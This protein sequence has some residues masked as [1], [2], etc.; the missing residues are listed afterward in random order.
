MI[1]GKG[2]IA[3]EMRATA[4]TA[5]GAPPPV[6][7]KEWPTHMYGSI[8]ARYPALAMGLSLFLPLVLT[9]VALG[10]TTRI[11][12]ETAAF[13]ATDTKAYK[14]LEA[15]VNARD[16]WEGQVSQDPASPVS[17]GDAS[18]RVRATP[19]YRITLQ[20][21]LQCDDETATAIPARCTTMLHPLN[22]DYVRG[23]EQ[24]ATGISTRFSSVCWINNYY[25]GTTLELSSCAPVSSV[26]Q[27]FYPSVVDQPPYLLLDGRGDSQQTLDENMYQRLL[28]NPQIDWFVDSTFRTSRNTRVLRSQ[29]I[30][31]TPI[32]RG[33]DENDTLDAVDSYVRAMYDAVHAVPKPLGTMQ[34]SVGGDRVVEARVLGRI[35]RESFMAPIAV[36]IIAVILFAHSR[37]IVISCL[38]TI[39]VLFTYL[40]TLSI[41]SLANDGKLPLLSLISLFFTIVWAVDGVLVVYDNFV[42]SGIIATTGRRNTLRV[43]QRIS[44][45]LRRGIK[46]IFIAH[47]CA[48]VAFCLNTVSP[49][50]E[51]KHFAEFMIIMIFVSLYFFATYTP[52]LVLF[53]HFY[54]AKR[55]RNLQRQRDVMLEQGM[56]DRYGPMAALLA[57]MEDIKAVT[58]YTP[59]AAIADERDARALTGKQRRGD[60]LNKVNA[61]AN[62]FSA[63][64][65]IR[66][67]QINERKEV[68]R[69]RRQD[70]IADAAAAAAEGPLAEGGDAPDQPSNEATSPARRSDDGDGELPEQQSNVVR[71]ES[72]AFNTAAAQ[73]A[74]DEFVDIAQGP[75]PREAGADRT[76]DRTIGPL[77]AVRPSMRHI[78][79]SE[80]IH[81]PP[82]LIFRTPASVDYGRRL[83]SARFEAKRLSHNVGVPVSEST[84]LTDTA[85]RHAGNSGN[86]DDNDDGVEMLVLDDH[87]HA[88]TSA[89]ARA[90]APPQL[91]LPVLDSETRF[92]DENSGALDRLERIALPFHT[93]WKAIAD[94]SEILAG[95]SEASQHVIALLA[96]RVMSNL[97]GPAVAPDHVITR[98]DSPAQAGARV[99]RLGFI[100]H[101]GRHQSTAEQTAAKTFTVGWGP[102]KKETTV[103]RRWCCGRFGSRVGETDD[104]HDQRIMGKKVKHE[105]Y[106]RC[107]RFFHNF[108]AA[109]IH[110]VRRLLFALLL[111]L[112]AICIWGTTELKPL[113]ANIQLL[114]DN[115]NERKFALVARSFGVV[116]GNCDFCGGNYRAASETLTVAAPA[117]LSLCIEQGYT[118]LLLDARIDRCGQCFGANDCV[119]CRDVAFGGYELDSCGQCLPKNDSRTDNCRTCDYDPTAGKAVCQWCF[120]TQGILGGGTSCTVPCDDT[121][122]PPARGR[123][124]KFTGECECHLSRELGFFATDPSADT[125]CSICAGQF[126][127]QP[128]VLFVTTGQCRYDCTS[129]TTDNQV[130]GTCHNRVCTGCPKGFI[131]NDCQFPDPAVCGNHGVYNALTGVCACEAGYGGAMCLGEASCNFRGRLLS[132]DQSPIATCVC[133]GNWAGPDCSVCRCQNGGLCNATDGTCRCPPGWGGANCAQCSSSC[134][135]HGSCPK[136]VNPLQLSPDACR[137]A[138]CTDEELYTGGWCLKCHR[139]FVGYGLRHMP[140]ITASPDQSGCEGDPDTFWNATAGGCF[141]LTS[142]ELGP[143]IYE[144]TYRCNSCKGYWSGLDCD[145][146]SSPSGSMGSCDQN[147]AVRGCDY[148]LYM[149][150]DPLPQIDACG[151]CGGTSSCV[152]CDGV[153]RNPPMRVDSCGVCGGD[154]NC[155]LKKQ[156]FD[157]TFV[158]GLYPD[159]YV[160]DLDTVAFGPIKAQPNLD[161]MSPDGQK[162]M[163]SMCAQMVQQTT[164]PNTRSLMMSCPHLEF[165]SWI[166]NPNN[167]RLLNFTRQPE[168]PGMDQQVF[169]VAFMTYLRLTNKFRHVGFDSPIAGPDRVAR[170]ATIQ[171]RP[172]FNLNGDDHEILFLADRFD[173]LAMSISKASGAFTMQVSERYVQAHTQLQGVSGLCWALGVGFAV[174]LMIIH[175]MSCSITSTL[176]ACGAVGFTCLCVLSFFTAF[177]FT[178]GAVEQVGIS[179]LLGLSVEHTVHILDTFLDVVQSSSSHLFARDV[180]RLAA[181]RTALAQSATPILASSVTTVVIGFLYSFSEVQPFRRASEIAILVTLIS[182]ITTLVF[183]SA[184]LVMVGPTVSYRSMVI[185]GITTLCWVGAWGVVIFALYMAEVRGP[186]G[187]IAIGPKEEEP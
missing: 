142:R 153:V 116:S 41:Y 63:E 24:A 55:R 171:V 114:S 35:D 107:E 2:T 86:Y 101:D 52:A 11:A 40:C 118:S 176:I 100:D 25:S 179:L 12:V 18:G 7:G 187:R 184:V 73:E 132:L 84:P 97:L 111:V 156:A 3:P 160:P 178:L 148:R 59:Y 183:I 177:G 123:C 103:R 137:A 168:Y 80:V 93:A 17:S 163:V 110:R 65:I 170:Y 147:G 48:L 87:G 172:V 5:D 182:M 67:R 9:V 165:M 159:Y 145:V 74:L 90:D 151:V 1:H 95:D 139:N 83:V 28:R 162:I 174:F 109:G 72:K 143:I 32:S 152:G 157:I 133:V 64:W 89:V 94:E 173:L 126:Y 10:Q 82:Q 26:T 185:A 164:G 15:L 19:S 38:G 150:G 4:R 129:N 119:D 57:A 104:E 45:V 77:V 85:A 13:A 161:V 112:I 66:Y 81:I 105:G 180:S 6:L 58:G 166:I 33:Y 46:G 8:L 98:F 141:E 158:L 14:N 75:S 51:L 138:F 91:R 131:G 169:T 154:G 120:R 175:I 88:Q 128:S 39:Q 53:H 121:I 181:L 155:D 122:C 42:H 69:R 106:G 30:L 34:L 125:R 96:H 62:A 117:A 127:P 20:F 130:C 27:Y 78:R 47:A 29:I 124:N 167:Y 68:R 135:A 79:T 36:A 31:G 60:G 144:V 21:E 92:G 136:P 49:I 140:P 146:C 70:E 50:G 149:P 44:L 22:L 134:S 71:I 37:S 23:V 186:D 43:E 61:L 108:W 54:F 102:W 56:R 99:G 76:V 16:Y 115:S 113:D